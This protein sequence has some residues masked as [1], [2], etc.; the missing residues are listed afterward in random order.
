VDVWV[1]MEWKAKALV[2]TEGIVPDQDR[3]TVSLAELEIASVY[4]F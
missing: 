1:I 3:K 2:G 4:T